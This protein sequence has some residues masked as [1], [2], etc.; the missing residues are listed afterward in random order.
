MYNLFLDDIRIPKD[1][2]NYMPTGH[3]SVYLMADWVIVRDYDDFCNYIRKHGLPDLVSFDHDLS[4]EHYEDLLKND[5]WNKLDS[6]IKLEYE[7]YREKT[8]FECAK[9]LTEY[10][11][12]EKLPLPQYIVH[13][14]NPVGKANILGLLGNF[15]KYQS[16][17]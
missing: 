16:K 5:N 3:R 6:D 8:G 11:L 2:S 15:K 1:C 4:D 17:L 12:N 9:W 14:R 7:T 13:S 10:C